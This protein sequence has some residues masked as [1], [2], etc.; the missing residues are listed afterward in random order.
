MQ[1]VK[2]ETQHMRKK[3]NWNATQCRESKKNATNPKIAHQIAAQHNEP[4]L[5]CNTAKQM[6][7][8]NKNK[9]IQIMQPANPKR[10][11]NVGRIEADVPII[12]CYIF[13]YI[14][15][16]NFSFYVI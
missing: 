11:E 3:S 10:N 14:I 9:Q 12:L 13:M 15:S 1:W 7:N 5:Q 4:K 16:C 6:Q 2:N 8:Q